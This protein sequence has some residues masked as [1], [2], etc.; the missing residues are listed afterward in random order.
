VNDSLADAAELAAWLDSLNVHV[1]LIPYNPI[2]STPHLRTTERPEREAFAEILRSAGFITTIRY[3]LG[4]DIAAACGQLV[5]R[6]NREIA[7]ELIQT[8]YRS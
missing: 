2:A 3:S 1:N 6:K 7:R 4:A 8:A 5:Q